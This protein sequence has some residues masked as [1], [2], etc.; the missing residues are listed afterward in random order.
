MTTPLSKL[1]SVN[2]EFEAHLIDFPIYSYDRQVVSFLGKFDPTG[3]AELGVF[4]W[5]PMANPETM[6]KSSGWTEIWWTRKKTYHIWERYRGREWIDIWQPIFSRHE[7]GAGTTR[8]IPVKSL[9]ESLVP[10]KERYIKKLMPENHPSWQL[11]K[12]KWF[13]WTDANTNDS[14]Y[15]VFNK[16]IPCVAIGSSRDQVYRM[17]DAKGNAS[18][19]IYFSE[20]LPDPTLI[21]G[22][23]WHTNW[24]PIPVNLLY[25]LLY[26]KALA[27]LDSLNVKKFDLPPLKIHD[28]PKQSST[29]FKF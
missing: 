10:Q 16:P 4:N 11:L 8:S 12:N 20:N 5:L 24:R 19:F 29:I 26:G 9:L 6:A 27:P 14:V 23:Q 17:N 22:I 1:R 21:T 13:L 3:D 28:A 2:S 18:E 7:T 25:R 15:G